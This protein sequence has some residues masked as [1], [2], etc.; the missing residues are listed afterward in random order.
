MMFMLVEARD[1]FDDGGKSSREP[2]L[3]SLLVSVLGW[4][5][6]WPALVVWLLAASR[7]VD[8]WPGVGC[9]FAA[10]IIAAWRSLR[11]LPMEG[12]TQTKQ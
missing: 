5:L 10:V 9:A 12:L 6:P 3:V 4:L 2:W 7:V 1:P 11:S 8:G